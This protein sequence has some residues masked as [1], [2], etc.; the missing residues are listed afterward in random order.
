MDHWAKFHFL[1]AAAVVIHLQN[2]VFSIFG[3]PRR[4]HSA[5]N[6]RCE[7]LRNITVEKLLGASLHQYEG[8]NEPNWSEWLPFKYINTFIAAKLSIN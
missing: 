7:G 5:R 8:D 1:T 2:H 6:T 3:I 4:L